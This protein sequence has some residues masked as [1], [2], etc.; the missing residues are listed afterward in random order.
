M[1]IVRYLI[2]GGTAAVTDLFFLY[3]FTDI[4]G[5]WYVYSTPLAFLIAFGVSF[6]LQKY[7]TFRDHSKEGMGKQGT[8]YFIVSVCNMF[9]NSFL[10]IAF[11]DY[12]GLHYIVSQIVAAGLIAVM[13]FFVYQKFIFNRKKEL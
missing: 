6:S 1:K 8:V 3:F 13:S 4:C 2:S 7:W 11:T 9:L 10:V 12:V 5:L